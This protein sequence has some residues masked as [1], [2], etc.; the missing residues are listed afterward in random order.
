VLLHAGQDEA[1][2]ELRDMD[3]L[4]LELVL[5]VTSLTSPSRLRRRLR[6]RRAFTSSRQW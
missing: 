5:Q 1:E 2:R 4:L 6:Q 3:T